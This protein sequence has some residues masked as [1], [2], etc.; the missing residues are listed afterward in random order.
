MQ[1]IKKLFSHSF[2]VQKSP[3]LPIFFFSGCALFLSAYTSFRV[4]H[5]YE[6]K[7]LDTSQYLESQSKITQTFLLAKIKS[8]DAS[9]SLL[10]REFSGQQLQRNER[11]KS[12]LLGFTPLLV[13]I[14]GAY[15]AV[16]GENGISD[17]A[18][19]HQDALYSV[20]YASHEFFQQQQNNH[21][22]NLIVSAPFL[23]ESSSEW[24]VTL[25]RKISGAR[26]G[27][28]GV[29]MVTI[30]ATY[31]QNLHKDLGL[32]KFSLFS[33]FVGPDY[34]YLVRFPEVR[35]AL[36][37]MLSEASRFA[38][39]KGARSLTGVVTSPIDGVERIQAL[40]RIGDYPIAIAL[41][42]NYNGGWAYGKQELSWGVVVSLTFC[43]LGFLFTI[44]YLK[45]HRTFLEKQEEL[46]KSQERF[47]LL[48]EGTRDGVMDWE[49]KTAKLYFSPYWNEMLGLQKIEASPDITYLHSLIHPGDLQSFLDAWQKLTSEHSVLR[50]DLRMK[51][52]SGR[53]PLHHL[54]ASGVWDGGEL[55]RVTGVLQNFSSQKQLVP[56]LKTESVSKSDQGEFVP[57]LQMEM[58]KP[59]RN[60]FGTIALLEETKLDKE[61]N[62]FVSTLRMS[63]HDIFRSFN[64][65]VDSQRLAQLQWHEVDFSLCDLL[66]NLC[67]EVEGEVKHMEITI[68]LQ[69]QDKVP[70]FCIGDAGRIKRI[71]ARGLSLLAR[72]AKVRTRIV[73]I[74]EAKS[75]ATKNGKATKIIQISMKENGAGISKQCVS[76]LFTVRA[77]N[78]NSDFPSLVLAKALTEKLGGDLHVESTEGVGSLLQFSLPLKPSSRVMSPL[79]KTRVL[80]ADASPESKWL[81]EAHLGGNVSVEV[82]TN[83]EK[84]LEIFCE[85]SFDLVLVDFVLP[86]RNEFSLI[87][88]IRAAGEQKVHTP[89]VG[90][91]PSWMQIETIPAEGY[92]AFLE[93]PLAKQSLLELTKK[94]LRSHHKNAA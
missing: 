40:E 60:I 86:G 77:D 58:Q 78:S 21:E 13:E 33:V 65:L 75:A 44:I 52:G 2:L 18:T 94:L 41:G 79:A 37:Q 1:K 56:V 89:I 81:L 84:T 30:P 72:S 35:S 67:R 17:S 50:L 63:A 8:L 9:L 15:F 28:L 27:F 26:G 23:E 49:P 3:L 68:E 83:A 92:D 10:A 57:R 11:I 43:L 82:A 76:Q 51:H 54:R 12:R 70:E 74:V 6:Q 7:N 39:A 20:S 25:S 64:D 93:K 87:S 59:V 24:L 61:Q 22:N 14:P 48:F 31:F 42:Q 38:L 19:N 46:L 29:V 85:N 32:E 34:K 91:I 16:V 45:S 88:A 5:S 4:L 62:K 69:L 71:L 53:W 80:L 66:Q 55:V 73:L 90:L 36:G 47:Q